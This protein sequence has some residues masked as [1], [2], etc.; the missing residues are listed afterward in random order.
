MLRKSSLVDILSDIEY[1]DI[2]VPLTDQLKS[3]ATKS[4]WPQDIIDAMSV[5]VN[6][7][8][9]VYVDYPK[10]SEEHTSELQSH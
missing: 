3:L 6:K 10:R 4:D 1:D 9:D 7:N 8:F 2:L 5:K